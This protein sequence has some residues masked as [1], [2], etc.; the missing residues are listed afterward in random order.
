VYLNSSVGTFT[1]LKVVLI[2]VLCVT[3][4]FFQKKFFA[5][6]SKSISLFAGVVL[7]GVLYMQAYVSHAAA[8]F[9]LPEFSVF[10]TFLHLAAKEFIIGGI[11]V[12]LI[13]LVF[14]AR[15]QAVNVY[16]RCAVNFDLLASIGLLVA[17]VTGV[18]ITWLHLKHIENIHVTE[19]GTRFIALLI[20]TVIFGA[21]R[22][23]H[24]CVV[25]QRLGK[26]G[27]QKVLSITL[28]GE[29]TAGLLV[30]FISG[31]ISIT[32]PPFSVEKYNF[33]LSDTTEGLAVHLDVHPL[34]HDLFRI[35]LVDIDA[36]ESV[37]AESLTIT[38][39]NA[40]R[41][42]GPNVVET[43]RRSQGVYVFP[44]ASLSPAGEWEVAVIAGQKGEYDAQASFGIVY[45]EDVI[46]SKHSDDAR[47][48][49]DFA[50]LMIVLGLG[51][52]VFS[53]FL[54]IFS[55]KQIQRLKKEN[56]AMNSVD[57][58]GISLWMM[59]TGAVFGVL[60][61][62]YASYLVFAQT[63][64]ERR[65]I[66]DGHEWQQAFP[67]RNFEATSPNALIGCTVHEGHYHFVDEKEYS[68]FMKSL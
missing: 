35:S 62:F 61:L 21:F 14:L 60:L 53:L 24:Q 36:M 28:F 1:A 34:E 47:I 64:F 30:L 46:E 44:L 32:T 50:M 65:C 19:W 10:V 26:N 11:A 3:F 56:A 39:T 9:F 7:A 51:L 54:S 13:L 5:P 15:K 8:S 27:W 6:S 2:T 31:Y 48:F 25:H 33:S 38:A 42:I 23:F 63:S 58:Q 52:L 20:A 16:R 41:G 66:Q 45:P 67:T 4:V 37:D 43:E 40:Q 59:R 17:A 18:Y 12:L 29:L 57:T 22:L 49:D 55:L 68:E